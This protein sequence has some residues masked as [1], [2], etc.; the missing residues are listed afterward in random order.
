MV[1]ASNADALGQNYATA[2]VDEVGNPT[3]IKPQ[4]E[5]P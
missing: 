4:Q 3:S 5:R 1:A 2:A